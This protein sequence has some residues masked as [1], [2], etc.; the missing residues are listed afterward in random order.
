MRSL[1]V[2]NI[3]YAL[4]FFI[5]ISMKSIAQEN[6]GMS[7]GNYA[8]ST[9]VWFNPASIADSRLKFDINLFGVNTYFNNNY[10]LVK[11]D[12]FVRRLFFK[13]P[14]NSSFDAVKSDLL[15]ETW[16]VNR[17]VNARVET[18][19]LFPLSFMATIGKKSAIAFRMNNRT[20]NQ[21]DSLNPELARFFYHDRNYPELMGKDIGVDSLN[22]RFL[23]WQEISFT[24]SRVI[25]S[26]DHH[27]LKLGATLKWLG[28]NGG[29]YIQA[30]NANVN[31]R[32]SNT[33]SLSS[34]LI[35]YART[36]R[37]DIGTFQRRDILNNL[38][39]KSWGWDAGL[40][41]EFR[42][43]VRKFKYVDTDQK[44]QQRRDLNKYLFRIGL[45]LVDMGKFNLTK[46]PLTNDHFANIVNW[47]FSEVGAHN[48][49]DF[50]TAY[51]KQITYMPGASTT[52]T[53]RLP[54]AIIGN[55]DLH[56]FNGFYINAAIKAPFDGF[57]KSTDAYV[58]PNRWIAITPRFEGRLFGLYVPVVHTN[59]RTN[60]GATI[61]FGPLYLGSTNLSE[62]LT[63]KSA[64]EGD[65][66]VGFRIPVAYGKPSRFTKFV[67][68]TM[69][70]GNQD[71]ISKKSTYQQ[72]LDSLAKEID[73]LKSKLNDTKQTERGADIY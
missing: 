20:I 3:V 66:H 34:P 54:A 18:N 23:N 4:A 57:K 63:N 72:Q 47:D 16:P 21:V 59:K 69:L 37:A 42:A 51:S 46:K 55:L 52:F 39:D 50:D 9:G 33:M 40:V 30:E 41:Y 2:S 14:Y 17:D 61:R 27:F 22:Y 31:F 19:L 62:I 53:Y 24:Y 10:L 25:L 26:T 28:A 58:S 8:G 32:D 60:I 65:F 44:E 36:E 49:S 35:K 68:N 73:L 67:N 45:S 6:I 43:K 71:T 48:L 1:S 5:F 12:A 38:E 56:L 29:G 70:S 15:E 13:D 11:R 7:T 64:Y